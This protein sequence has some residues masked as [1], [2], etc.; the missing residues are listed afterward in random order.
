MELEA[1]RGFGSN[2][3]IELDADTVL[4]QGDNGT[5]KTSITDG[6]LWLFTDEIPRLKERGKGIRKD[7]SDP[8]VNRYRTGDEAV[9]K[10]AIRVDG[11]EKRTDEETLLEFERVGTSKRS[12]LRVRREKEVLDGQNAEALLAQA[13]GEFTHAQFAHAVHG[14]GVLQQHALLAALE[15]GASMHERLAEMVGLE[16]VNHFAKGASDTSRAAKGHLKEAEAVRD[17]LQARVQEAETSLRTW[18]EREPAAES[19]KERVARIADGCFQDLP[20]GVR[21]KQ[22]VDELSKFSAMLQE[23]FDIGSAARSRASALVAL[24]S[25]LGRRD[26]SSREFEDQLGVLRAEMDRS[27][28]QAPARVQMAEAAIRL[29]GS[30]CPVCG[31]AIDERSVESHL[32]EVLSSAKGEVQR[33]S[34]LRGQFAEVEARLQSARLVEA[35]LSDAQARAA[36]AA[37]LL[38]GRTG[39]AIW[40]AIETSWLENDQ[41]QA[42]TDALDLLERLAREGQVDARRSGDE[43]TVR[44]SAEIEA[45]SAEIGSAE[46]EVKE[47][48]ARV[49]R[50]IA[51][52]KAAHRAA[53]R[54]VEKALEQLQPSLAEVF[55]RLSPHPTFDELRAQQDVYY[56]KNQVVPHAFDRKNEVGGH[57]ALIFSEGQLNVVA[58]SYFLGLAINAGDGSLPFV[59]LDDTLAAMDVVNVLGFADLCRRLREKKQLIVTTHD[60]RFAGLLMRKFAP[61]E[62]GVST[63]LVEL[64][65]WSEDG[66]IVR[67]GSQPVAEILPLPV[68]STVAEANQEELGAG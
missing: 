9:V 34:Q 35:E 49:E 13:F 65:G 64:D 39:D 24:E 48:K 43:R 22:P 18:R 1:F 61:R 46:S 45:A 21:L 16:R 58:L 27:I 23:T 57:P 4:V 52:D 68:G 30:D 54:I 25:V 3:A 6:L 62:S 20:E 17:R 14:W 56:G 41:A 67:C 51:L 53:E 10:L 59:V 29:L 32:Q 2:Q 5:G 7:G 19:E 50:A 12:I 63:M 11:L 44:W 55:D 42:L 36:E 8:I 15:G 47:A 38:R 33:A 26:L 40:I 31:Q 60:R 28:A 66:P 37:E